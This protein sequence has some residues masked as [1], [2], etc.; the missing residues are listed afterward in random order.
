MYATLGRLERDGLAELAEV[1]PGA[2][3][4]RRLYRITADGVTRVDEWVLTPQPPQ[5]YAA[6]SLHARVTI[7]LLS[8][9]D[10]DRVLADQRALHLVRMREL[11]QQ[12][13]S[14]T[15]REGRQRLAVHDLTRPR[16]RRSVC[17]CL[18]T[19]RAWPRFSRTP[20]GTPEFERARD[21]SWSTSST[22]P[23]SRV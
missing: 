3:P 19:C 14:A 22:P 1:E 7:A 5:E 16:C 17:C 4:E 10:A 23:A 21:V 15:G 13:R 2:G 9:R 11:L 20:R 18:R 6:S 12:R 8:G